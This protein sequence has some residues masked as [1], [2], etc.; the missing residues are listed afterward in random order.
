MVHFMIEF[1]YIM[2]GKNHFQFINKVKLP[3]DDKRSMI[4]KIRTNYFPRVSKNCRTN[5]KLITR[6]IYKFDLL[7]NS[8]FPREHQC[9]S[10]NMYCSL[11]RIPENKLF[12]C[13][14][15]I[16]MFFY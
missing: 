7:V 9:L 8:I 15:K 11:L 6:R 10:F 14:T 16:K 1:I 2:R 12:C 13:I 4:N 5:N 3:D